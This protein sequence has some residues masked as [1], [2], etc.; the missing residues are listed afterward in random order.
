MNA[1]NS[2]T[3]FKFDKSNFKSM[4]L[5]RATSKLFRIFMKKNEFQQDW[6]YSPALEKSPSLLK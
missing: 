1:N 3:T 5:K 6:I 2:S 4:G